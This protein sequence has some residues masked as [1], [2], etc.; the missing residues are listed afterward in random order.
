MAMEFLTTGQFK[1]F[2]NPGVLSVQLLSPHHSTSSRVTITR[3]TVDPGAKQV[4]HWS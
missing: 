4:T 1:E 3:V 2:S